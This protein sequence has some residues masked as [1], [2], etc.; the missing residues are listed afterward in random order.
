M[1]TPSD[2][3]AEPSKTTDALLR[4]AVGHGARLYASCAVQAILTHDG[5]VSEVVTEDGTVQT[6]HVVCA[7]G[8]WSSRLVRPLGLVLPNRWVRSTVARTTAGPPVTDA[9]VWAPRVSFR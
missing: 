1:I 7:A 3:H 6:T 8:A 9:G 4:A 5:M 2:G